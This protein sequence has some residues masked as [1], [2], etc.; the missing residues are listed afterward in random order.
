[1]HERTGARDRGSGTIWVVASMALIWFTAGTLVLAGAARIARHRARSAADLSALA[2][3]S[4]VLIAPETACRHARD[5]AVANHA[6]ITRCQVRGTVVVVRV[7]VPLRL[8]WFGD[9]HATAEARAG[10]R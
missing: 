6:S 9:H 3:A 10:P 2:G 1:M 7:E 5:L 8:P 4:R